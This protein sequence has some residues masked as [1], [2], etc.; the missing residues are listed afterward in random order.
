[1]RRFFFFYIFCLFSISQNL[2]AQAGEWVWLRGDTLADALG[3][4]GVQGVSSPSNDPPSLYEAYNFTDHYGNFWVYGGLNSHGI[5]SALWKY[6]PSTNEWTWMKGDSTTHSTGNFGV[7]GVPSSSNNPPA[8]SYCG[9]SWVDLDGN[10]WLFGG[11]GINFYNALW[12]YDVNTNEWTWMKGP[13]LPNQDGIYGQQGVPDV[14]N[15]PPTKVETAASWIDNNGDLWMFGG[16][17]WDGRDLN[18]LWRY[19]IATNTWTWMK[20]SKYSSRHSAHGTK[21]LEDST[22]TPG[23]RWMYSRWK[24][25]DGNLWMMGGLETWN[26]KVYSDLWR[27]NLATNNWA[28]MDGDTVGN[29]RAVYSTKCKQD[30]LDDPGGELENRTAWIDGGNFWALTYTSLWMYNVAAKQWRWQSGDTVYGSWNYGAKGVS[31]PT[32]YPFPRQGGSAWNDQPGHLYLFGGQGAGNDVW[33][34]T[35]DYTCAGVS[36]VLD[37]E[38]NTANVIVSPNPFNSN[39]SVSL[40]QPVQDKAV[41]SITN[42]LGTI[43]YIRQAPPGISYTTMLDLS[44]LPNGLYLVEV[45]ADGNR[46]VKKVVKQ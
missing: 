8:L 32:N 10:F 11:A 30:T 25:T 29:N 39:V 2:C 36:D 12:K 19:N 23:S 43:V 22:V 3:H 27:Y 18:D 34:Y 16:H 28:W 26:N 21:G 44:Y 35:I 46:T 24:D 45:I 42:L 20:G 9:L 33:K 7:Q 1:M 5:Y 13:M 15:Y 41:I 40:T 4:F 37:L 17:D 38:N 14:L 6:N 31:S